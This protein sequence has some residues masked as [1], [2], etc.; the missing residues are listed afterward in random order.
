MGI[1]ADVVDGK[2]V[3]SFAMTLPLG[4]FRPICPFEEALAQSWLD[5]PTIEHED[6]WKKS[7]TRLGQGAA[8]ENGEGPH[9][10]RRVGENVGP[11]QD[12]EG[13]TPNAKNPNE[14][15]RQH[16]ILPENQWRAVGAE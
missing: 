8:L 7:P 9:S 12:A 11:L 14:P 1:F 6:K 13:S 10:D 15:D 4:W 2:A 16:G 3:A 5:H